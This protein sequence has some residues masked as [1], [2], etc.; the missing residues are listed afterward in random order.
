MFTALKGNNC[1][2]FVYD[3]TLILATL[4]EPE[5]KD[6]EMPLKSILEDP[7][8]LAVKLGEEKF[9]KFM[10][11]MIVDWHQTGRIVALEKKYGMANTGYR[12]ADARRS[13]RNDRAAGRRLPRH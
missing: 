2:A 9:Y 12:A 3:D 6:Y 5:W 10:S 13:T 8:G 1:V 7:W 4:L 11:D